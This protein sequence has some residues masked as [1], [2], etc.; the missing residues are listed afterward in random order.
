MKN[1]VTTIVLF[2]LLPNISAA[3]NCMK[4]KE[5]MQFVAAICGDFDIEVFLEESQFEGK[6]DAGSSS[7]VK[8]VF[9]DVDGQIDIKGKKS[10][11]KNV[12]REQLQAEQASIRSCNQTMSTKLLPK[13]CDLN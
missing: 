13:L 9:L 2:F 4:P 7:L 12:P 1:V 8:K 10:V 5:I 11:S 6:V 3:E